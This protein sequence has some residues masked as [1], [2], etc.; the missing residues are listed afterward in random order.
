[1]SDKF[2]AIVLNQSGDKFT[3]EVKTLDKSFFKSGDVLVKVDYSGLNYKDSLIL[4][5][6]ARLVKEYP[7]IP[8]VDFSGKVI[9]SDS[10]NFYKGDNVVVTGCRVGEIYPG[11]FSQ[12]AKVNSEFLIKI[13]KTISNKNAMIL[14]T[15][16]F[17]SLM[18][19]FAIKAR[20]ELLLGEKVKDVLVTGSTGGVGSIAVMVLSKFGYNVTAIT[21]KK[22]KSNY[23]KELG[24]NNILD[25]K[26]FEGEPKLLGKGLWDGVVDTV[27][28]NILSNAIS[29][30][31]P[32]GI[33]AAC[34]NAG[35]IKLN[36]SVMPFIIRG[37]KL[38]GIDSV[39]ISR[40]RREFI[41]SQVTS[42]VDFKIL[43]KNIQIVN[44]EKL[45]NIFPDMLSGKTSGRTIIDLNK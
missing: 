7:H 31:K 5:N 44:L 45:L 2:K 14:G 25:R 26:E 10:A 29:Q 19:S 20:E 13:P 43:E 39:M 36:T 9:E 24:A 23:L 12:L 28:G 3:R 8:G 11:G 33:V 22:D 15:A 27:G 38:W 30:T 21:G 16:G 17:T 4:K 6:G 1:M 18:C 37:V 34:G 40:K 41:W 42:L 32:N 35:G